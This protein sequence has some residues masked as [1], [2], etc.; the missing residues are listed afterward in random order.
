MIDPVLITAVHWKNACVYG[1]IEVQEGDTCDYYSLVSL[2]ESADAVHAACSFVK[3]RN[4][5]EAI[6][7]HACTKFTESLPIRALKQHDVERTVATALGRIL[8]ESE[9]ANW[10][11]QARRLAAAPNKTSLFALLAIYTRSRTQKVSSALRLLK[12]NSPA[13][14]STAA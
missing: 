2:F 7:I 8:A 1:K 3:N 14:R 9:L 11:D 4:I 5:E 6:Q 13:V 10:H 12:K